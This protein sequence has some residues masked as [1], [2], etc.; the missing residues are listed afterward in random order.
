MTITINGD[1]YNLRGVI[2]FDGS[3]RELRQSY[4]H[5]IAYGLRSN[6]QWQCYDDL[7][8]QITTKSKSF[9]HYQMISDKS[10]LNVERN[11]GDL[12]IKLT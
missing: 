2:A 12:L 11:V 6:D 7:K 9:K 1:V 5:Y 3:A 8:D 4:G 10:Q